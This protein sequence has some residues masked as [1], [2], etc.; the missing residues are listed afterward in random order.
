MPAERTMIALVWLGAVHCLWI[1]FAAPSLA[2]LVLRA[3]PGLPASARHKVLFGAFLLATVGPFVV[4]AVHREAARRSNKAAD[5]SPRISSVSLMRPA[6]QPA[7][8]LE[9]RPSG[10]IPP[11][12]RTRSVRLLRT[13]R[14]WLPRCWMMG[15]IGMAGMVLL[16]SVASLRL[17]RRSRPAPEPVEREARR[18]GRDLKL[19]R[20]T[21]VLVHDTL[22]EPC[23]CRLIRP[24]IVLPAG[25]L[26]KAK[27]EVVSA[28]LAHELAHAL[29][30]D[31]LANL[32]QRFLEALAFFH[33][34]VRRLSQALR[35][36]REHRADAVAVRLTGDPRSLAEALESI[37][38]LRL[39]PRMRGPLEVAFG[40]ELSLLPRIQE[41][42]GMKSE[43]RRSRL[44]PLAVLAVSGLLG[45]GTATSGLALDDPPAKA[46][47]AARPPVAA[48]Q[49]DGERAGTPQVSYDVA[50]LEGTNI[51][52]FGPDFVAG[53]EGESIQITF[54]NDLER[55][56]LVDSAMRTPAPWVSGSPLIPCRSLLNRL[57]ERDSRDSLC[58]RDIFFRQHHISNI[59]KLPAAQKIRRSGCPGTARS[60]IFVGFGRRQNGGVRAD[61]EFTRCLHD[62]NSCSQWGK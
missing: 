13:A 3:R 28:V 59:G 23:L 19:R 20:N 5:R 42:L 48:P 29:H 1:G 36:Q 45:L 21:P 33:P 2:A 8:L 50:L 10:S 16:G 52:G 51:T 34:G 61:A 26:S 44:R 46:A 11:G 40:G 53:A 12:A 14:R 27:P 15:I 39:V 35:L 60:P 32:A 25:W 57:C 43:L 54:L 22:D 4:A 24:A 38:R 30:N 17:I 18:L 62:L 7:R 9:A 56:L 49:G 6:A 31:P 55:Q 41:I 47:V 58:E 37:A